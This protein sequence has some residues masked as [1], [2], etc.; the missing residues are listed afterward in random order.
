M[1]SFTPNMEGKI[2]IMKSKMDE[3]GD[4][5]DKLPSDEPTPW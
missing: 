4:E 5:D 2:R 1:E 3:L